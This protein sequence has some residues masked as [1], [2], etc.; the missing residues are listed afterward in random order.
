MNKLYSLLFILAL[1]LTFNVKTTQ[2]VKADTFT[3][4]TWVIDTTYS[5]NALRAVVTF[6]QSE[7]GRA[8]V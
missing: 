8:H 7:I 3:D 5:P 6:S 4:I 2:S 1:T